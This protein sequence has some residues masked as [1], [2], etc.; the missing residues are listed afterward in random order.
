MR[1]IAIAFFIAVSMSASVAASDKMDVTAVAQKWADAFNRGDFATSIQ[2]C[3]GEAV[4]IDDFP[5]HVWQ[6]AGACSKW[7]RDFLAYAAKAAISDAR[8][9]LGVASHLDVDSGYAYLVVPVGL[10]FTR[11]GKPVKDAGIVTMSLHKA[12]AGWQITGM[13][14]ADQS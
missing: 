12:K 9:T 7:Y 1:K 3:S 6:L 10:S 8:I 14:W 13:T 11:S 5:P 2:P 4:V